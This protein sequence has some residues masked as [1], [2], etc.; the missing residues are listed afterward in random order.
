M[1]HGFS[2]VNLRHLFR[3]PLVGCFLL[4]YSKNIGF[5][6]LTLTTEKDGT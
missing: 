3:T 2:P 5:K 4:V 6:I 1:P